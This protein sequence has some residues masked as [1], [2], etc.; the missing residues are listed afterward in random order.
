[1]IIL[2]LKQNKMQFFYSY[3]EFTWKKPHDSP[4]YPVG[5]STCLTRQRNQ[6]MLMRRK[7]QRTIKKTPRILF[8]A[9]GK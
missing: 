5:M 4:F 1:L 6:T 8:L 9:D 7:K 2:L 3:I